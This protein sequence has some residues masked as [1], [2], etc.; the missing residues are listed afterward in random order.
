MVNSLAY[1]DPTH[2][3]L[4]ISVAPTAPLGGRTITVTNPDGQ[5]AASSNGILTINPQANLQMTETAS[6]EP[7]AAGYHLT[8]NLI[9]TNSGP[10]SAT[11]VIVTETLPPNVTFISST[12]APSSQAG[13]QLTFNLGSV[14]SG[15]SVPIE[16]EVGVPSTTTGTIS[17]TGGVTSDIDDL[18]SKDNSATVTTTVLADSDHDGIPDSWEIAYG[19]NPNDPTDASLDFDG[20]GFTNLQEYIAGTN[21]NDPTSRWSATA[22]ASGADIQISFQTVTGAKYRVE[23]TDDLVNTPWSILFDKIA[24]TGSPLMVTDINALNSS[25]RFYRVIVSR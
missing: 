4:N 13:V 15:S 12:P 16:I 8:Y 1:T 17:A 5:T 19:L 6:P 23:T 3:T 2:L 22:V 25:H 10:D 18:N 24:G 11:N 21:P 14:P 20:D 9:A 7:V